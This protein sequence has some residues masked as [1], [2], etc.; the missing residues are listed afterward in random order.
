MT[1]FPAS[2]VLLRHYFRADT[3]G[4][5]CRTLGP[6]EDGINGPEPLPPQNAVRCLSTSSRNSRLTRPGSDSHSDPIA[7]SAV[8]RYSG[9]RSAEP[10]GWYRSTS[11][12]QEMR[13]LDLHSTGSPEAPDVQ[14]IQRTH[15]SSVWE[16]SGI[17]G[18]RS[19][20]ASV[21]AYGKRMDCVESSGRKPDESSTHR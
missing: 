11:D 8:S 1:P 15:R 10:E 21:I 20:R 19:D 18:V 16:I 12:R 6:G 5:T 4:G 14:R 3:D 2:I 17:N 7:R 9:G 13:A